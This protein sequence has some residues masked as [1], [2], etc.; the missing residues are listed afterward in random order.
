MTKAD[1]SKNDLIDFGEFVH[2]ILEHEKNLAVAFNKADLN[3]DGVIDLHELKA[4]LKSLD[5][6][7]SDKE[8]ETLMKK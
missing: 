2:Y 4:Y 7:L 5:V 6:E 3:A 1:R 8:A